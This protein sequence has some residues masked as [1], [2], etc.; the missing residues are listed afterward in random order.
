MINNIRNYTSLIN[1]RIEA[2]GSPSWRKL[3]LIDKTIENIE[4]NMFIK[5]WRLSSLSLICE[6]Y[7]D[8]FLDPLN[9]IKIRDILFKKF[10]IKQIIGFILINALVITSL[11]FGFYFDRKE[12]IDFSM[13]LLGIDAFAL[14]HMFHIKNVDNLLGWSEYIKI[15]FPPARHVLYT[16]IIVSL[17]SLLMSMFFFGGW[18]DAAYNYGSIVY[19]ISSGEVWR[20]VTGSFIHHNFAHLITNLLFFSIFITLSSYSSFTESV[21][22]FILGSVYSQIIY[23]YINIIDN[24]YESVLL[25]ISGGVDAL[26][27][28]ILIH[29]IFNSKNY[30]TGFHVMILIFICF[31]LYAPYL[32]DPYASTVAHVAGTMF[33][34]VYG[35]LSSLTYMNNA[36]PLYR[37]RD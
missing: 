21:Y 3:S 35:Y 19:N 30:P 8:E 12:M 11:A 17:L 15:L 24:S 31:G 7:S 6:P 9:N 10:K 4:I 14:A 37:F 28:R 18:K 32:L 16:I 1:I 26:C 25:G 2:S 23:V 34:I 36:S 5:K 22:V 20:L 29:S 13:A 33:G 27:G